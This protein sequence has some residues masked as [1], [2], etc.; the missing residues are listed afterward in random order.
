MEFSVKSYPIAPNQVYVWRGFKN[1]A[2]TYDEFAGFLG[3][4]FVPACSLLQPPVGLRA[5]YPTMIP[6]VNKNEALPDQTALMFWAT[7]ESHSL[8]NGTVAVRVYQNLHG[9]L[10]DM[11]RSKTQEVPLFLPTNAADFIA[12]QPYYLFDIPADWM[13]GNALHVVGSRPG[14]MAPSDFKNSIFNWAKDFQKN[15]S[16]EI[17]ATLLCCSHDYAVAWSHTNQH[18]FDIA[19][20]LNGIR[21]LL[22]VHLDIVPRP[23][24]YKQNLWSKWAGI[25]LL[26]PQ[27]TSLNIQL[28]RPEHTKPLP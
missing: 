4:V 2:K 26:D 17:D 6:Q 3:S 16:T 27:N 15:R 13:F 10:Y 24:K 19:D 9:E 5:Y 25:N 14:S 28:D 18:D 22:D 21:K 23:V 11:T 8:A 7:P 20:S 12:D 1:P